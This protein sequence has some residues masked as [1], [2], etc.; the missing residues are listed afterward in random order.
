MI[1]HYQEP[2]VG[3]PLTH[4]GLPLNEEGL[5]LPTYL[6]LAQEVKDLQ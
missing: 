1:D 4:Q 5:S 3:F 2:A 6:P